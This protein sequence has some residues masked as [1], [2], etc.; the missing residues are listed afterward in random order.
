M[1]HFIEDFWTNNAHLWGNDLVT[2]FPPEPNG[3][4]HLGHARSVWL[5]A[6]LAEK[7]GGRM[8]LRMDDTNPEKEDVSHEHAIAAS[9]RHLG[10]PWHGPVRYASDH[11]PG[12][13]AT[14]RAW[15]RLGIAFVDTSDKDEIRRMRGDLHRPGNRSPD[16]DKPIEWHL[17]MFARMTAGEFPD[18]G[19]VLRA[20]I[21]MASPNINLRD[22]VLY[23]I[24]HMEHARTKNS[25]CV[26]PTY[27]YAHPFCDV[28]EGIALSLC[29]LE[30][31]DHR[32]LY[33][34]VCEHAAPAFPGNARHKPVELEFSRLEI[35]NGLTSKR[36]INALVT[37]GKV[38]G[39]DDP[40]LLTLDALA[41]RGFPPK[42]LFKF[43]E[44]CGIGRS[45]GELPFSRLEDTL[46]LELDATAARRV[47][48]LDP[49]E[50][51]IAGSTM[52][53]STMVSNHPKDPTLGEREF[54]LSS[55]V[56][57][58]RDDVRLPGTVEKGFKRLEVGA[59]VR[60]MNLAI[61]TVTGIDEVDGR[62]TKVHATATPDAKPRATI[63]A[64]SRE[65]ARAVDV[66]V[67]SVMG[68]EDTPETCL[69]T[70]RAMVEPGALALRETFHA[71]RVGYAV[72]DARDTNRLILTTGLKKGF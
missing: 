22:P 32:P 42:V 23:R 43:I 7:F 65:H 35:T 13:H 20:K 69:A 63:H 5:N 16:A 52:P 59:C 3:R 58:E 66:L 36:R 24:K 30:F 15:I 2:R 4:L 33:D 54:G 14:A 6:S 38:E 45:N 57:V 31:E 27:D 9:L 39:W 64:L 25:W 71:P 51:D 41:R 62:I 21:D 19:P 53:R 68:P 10:I 47:L 17:D 72:V 56:W 18:G 48:V 26:Y 1:A 34:W 37:E 40:R 44:D 8:H 67:P 46:R 60:L 29:T 12:M 11:F 61:V 70:H 55:S 50:L 28:A 49:V